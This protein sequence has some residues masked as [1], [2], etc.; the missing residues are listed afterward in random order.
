MPKFSGW[1][2]PA[3]RTAL[4]DYRVLCRENV[5]NNSDQ[6]AQIIAARAADQTRDQIIIGLVGNEGMTL[7]AATKL[8]ADTARTE[9]WTSQVVSHKA[10]ALVYLISNYGDDWNADEVAAAVIELV[11]KYGVA[12]S[13]ARDYCKAHS[14]N[15]GITHPTSDPR[16]LMFQYLIDN[17]GTD[18][19]TLKAGFK[20]YASEE[21]GRSPSNINE[22]WK[23]YDL[24]LALTAA[25]AE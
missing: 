8:Y 15:S 24:H 17:A 16:A 11:D 21:L 12:E 13:T 10:D 4:P 5:M 7:N 3:D 18:Y 9:G 23:G 20:E 2:R 19:D 6:I 14:Y 22:Y 25:A 1:D